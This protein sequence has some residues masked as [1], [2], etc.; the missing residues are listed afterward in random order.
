M[1]LLLDENLPKRLKLDLHEHEAFTARDMGWN[2][3]KNGKLLK[4]MLNAGFHALLTFDKNI[5][6]QQNFEFYPITIFILIADN[7][8]YDLLKPLIAKIQTEIDAGDL[9]PGAILIK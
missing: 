9:K 2:G 3:L 1:R 5:Q 8:T 7:N 4:E 6:D